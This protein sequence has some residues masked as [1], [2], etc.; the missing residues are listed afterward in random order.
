MKLAAVAII[1]YPDNTFVKNIRTYID[2]VE[3]LLVFDNSPFN[4]LEKQLENNTKIK[5][6]WDGN[7]EGIAKRLNSAIEICMKENFDFLLTMDQDSS[8][9][10]NDLKRYKSLIENNAQDN[11]GMYGV[12]HDKSQFS[13]INDLYNFNKLLITSGSII[14]L[15]NIKNL[16]KFNEDLYI[17]GVDTEYCL[18]IFNKKYNTILFNNIVLS[19]QIGT[20]TL[21]FTP[22]LKIEERKIHSPT[23]IYYITRNYFFLRKL[24]KNQLQH[25]KLKNFL[26]EVKN[27]ILY[28][29]EK[30]NF[31]KNILKGYLD[32]KKNKMGKLCH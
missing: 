17:D 12:L 32:F 26:N 7:N 16:G 13:S 8:F 21:T 5:Y 22:S 28:G 14:P 27:G 3:M 4:T 25:L 23:R 10:T 20:T 31:I 11:I 29:N 19:H 30:V 1:Y 18:R 24:Y 2:D 9:N 15:A 6:L